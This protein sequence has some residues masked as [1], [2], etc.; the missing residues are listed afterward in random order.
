LE[1]LYFDIKLREI[2]SRSFS[3][4]EENKGDLCWKDGNQQLNELKEE[5]KEM[6]SAVALDL[7][8]L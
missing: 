1:Y 5:L 2:L 3:C 6:K 7:N 8:K 4:E